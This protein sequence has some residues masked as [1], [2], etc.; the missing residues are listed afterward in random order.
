MDEKV[1]RIEKKMSLFEKATQNR[2]EAASP[3]RYKLYR[4]PQTNIRSKGGG[5]RRQEGLAFSRGGGRHW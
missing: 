1:T 4:P 3:K 5:G 2:P